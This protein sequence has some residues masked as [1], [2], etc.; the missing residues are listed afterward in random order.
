M[1]IYSD[2]VTPQDSHA[3][4]GRVMLPQQVSSNGLTA[5]TNFQQQ[6]QNQQ[7]ITSVNLQP[8]SSSSATLPAGIPASTLQQNRQT[9]PITTSFSNVP[10]LSIQSTPSSTST[11]TLQLNN[12]ASTIVANHQQQQLTKFF[13]L[14]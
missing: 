6:H 11:N 3:P 5:T 12:T 14:F 13:F 4:L 9:S 2:R 7:V 10:S 8:G 1:Q